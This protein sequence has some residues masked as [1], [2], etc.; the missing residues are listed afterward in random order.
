VNF[1]GWQ[2]SLSD[3]YQAADIFISSSIY[4]AFGLTFLEAGYHK[5][6]IISTNVEGIPEVV[7]NEKTGLLCN[8]RDYNV[9]SENI[10][11]LSN[12]SQLRS[13]L[14]KN[15]YKYVTKKFSVSDMVSKYEAVY[16]RQD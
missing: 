2:N 9:M 10:I 1:A 6:P 4:E 5:L 16:N 15:G 12:D 13:L 7:L 11:R 14:G 8:P 3:Y